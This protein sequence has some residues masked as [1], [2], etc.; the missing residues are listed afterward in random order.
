VK[1]QHL[2][3]ALTERFGTVADAG[4]PPRN[5][6]QVMV[7]DYLP[8]LL[9]AVATEPERTP[10]HQHGVVR[11]VDQVDEL[12][13]MELR[14]RL[15]P[16]LFESVDLAVYGR[17]GTRILR[18]SCLSIVRQ[19]RGSDSAHRIIENASPSPAWSPSP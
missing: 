14:H 6:E 2:D 15:P 9:G 16:S 17:R 1:V 7:V 4:T 19:R 11:Q 12:L 5:R 10:C 3:P 8:P 18:T 13:G